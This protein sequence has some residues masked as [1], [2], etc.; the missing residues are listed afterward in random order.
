[1][2]SLIFSSI[3]FFVLFF[4]NCSD[5]IVQTEKSNEAGK[6][7][8]KIDKQNAPASVVFVKAYL[9]KE[10]SEPIFGTLDLLSDST[11]DILLD[12]ID[13]GTWHLKVDAEDDSGLVLYTGETDVQIFAGFTTQVYLTLTPTGVGTGSIYINVI[14][15]VP[16]NQNWIDFNNNPLLVTSHNYYDEYGVA[17]PQI[18][19]ENGGYKM[20]YLGIAASAGKYVLYAVSNDGIVWNKPFAHPI[21]YP[22]NYSAWDSWAVHPGAVFKDNDGVYKMYYCGYADQYSQWHIG[23]AT[24]IDGITWTKHPQPVLYG[25]SGWE[26][27]IGASSIIK[28]DGTYFLYYYGRTLPNYK[29]GVATSSDGINFIKYSGNPIIS[30]TASWELSGVLYASVIQENAS[31]KMVYGNSNGSGFGLAT[32]SDGLNWTKANNNP[33]FTNQNTSN[34]WAA[35]KIVY[36]NWLKLQNESRIY[37]SGTTAYSDEL[38]IGMMRKS[39]N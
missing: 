12:E 17:Q 6:I 22:G 33:F 14:W 4:A 25:T 36:P 19:F 8:L 7:L 34:N 9:T 24:S 11:A 13:A 31:L 10:N 23:L 29:I 16:I 28:K 21:L 15:G 39:G 30:N 3:L 27:Q 20:Y 1:M 32:S 37:Y 2:K 5:D 26:Y 18:F 35:G 38:R